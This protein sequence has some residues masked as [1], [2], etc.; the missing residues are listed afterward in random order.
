MEFSD[1]D[2]NL[3]S[4]F[5]R[6]DIAKHYQEKLRYVL[7]LLHEN[8]PVICKHSKRVAL[9]YVQA[10]KQE[11]LDEKIGVYC[12]LTHD[13]GQYVLKPKVI[14]KKGKFNDDDMKEMRKHPGYAYQFL[15]M[16][17]LDFSAEVAIRE[18]LFQKDPYPKRIPKNN[19]F[20]IQT[21][22]MISF[23]S[24]LL[25]LVDAYDSMKNVKEIDSQKVT[26]NL[27]HDKPSLKSITLSLYHNYIF[28]L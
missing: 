11:N 1:L 6:L 14:N 2:A 16:M 13:I 10:L 18:H 3:E 23:Y 15:K 21:M 19:K 26:Q 4:E 12:G 22:A 24:L 28:D 25:S 7:S 27:F 20:S 17:N 5:N 8:H 9:L